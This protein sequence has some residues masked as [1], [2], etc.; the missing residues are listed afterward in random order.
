MQKAPERS[1]AFRFSGAGWSA[2]SFDLILSLSKD[3]VAAERAR[4]VAPHPA[5]GVPP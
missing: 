2:F 1:G 3:E 4:S 5:G